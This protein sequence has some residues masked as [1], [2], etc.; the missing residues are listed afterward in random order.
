VLPTLSAIVANVLT[1]DHV[2]LESH[3]KVCIG[4]KLVCWIERITLTGHHIFLRRTR[5]KSLGA[6]E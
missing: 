5:L 1:D 4:A 6:N 2:K 3:P